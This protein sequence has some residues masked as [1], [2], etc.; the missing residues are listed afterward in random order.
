MAIAKHY[1]QAVFNWVRRWMPIDWTTSWL[2]ARRGG[3]VAFDAGQ[4]V[5]LRNVTDIDCLVLLG[6][7]GL[8]K[9]NEI[10][11]WASHL[12]DDGMAVD[13]LHGRAPDFAAALDGLLSSP[14]HA[15][16]SGDRKPW[17][18]LV[19]GL[20]EI[21]PSKEVATLLAG[22]LD[23]LFETHRETGRL[24]FIVT[25][26]TSG[27][28]EDFDRLFEDRW[29]SETLRKLALVPLDRPAIE[30]AIA[31]VEEDE[32]KRIDLAERLLAPQLR[33]L[34]GLPIFLKLLLARYR[35]GAVA[36]QQPGDLLP[37]AIEGVLANAPEEDFEKLMRVVG[38][39]A[40]ACLFSGHPRLSLPGARSLSD[41][42]PVSNIAGG[43]EPAASGPFVVTPAMMARCLHTGLFTELEPDVFEWSHRILSDF[44]AARYL[45][46]HQLSAEQIF[47]MVA[48]KEVAGPG[49][50]PLQL[51]EMAGWVASLSPTFFDLLLER[52]PEVLLRAQATTLDASQQ[53][54]LASALLQRIGNDDLLEQYH[55]LQP[56]LARLDH[57]GLAEQLRPVIANDEATPF[58]RR[59]AID[60][61]VASGSVELAD[62][63]ID[64]ALDT[65]RDA[66][67]RHLA[68]RAGV[69]LDCP[70]ARLRLK[71]LLASE[72]QGDDEDRL[73]GALLDL[74]WPDE[75]SFRELLGALSV[76]RK[77]NFIGPYQL[78]LHRFVPPDL[79]SEM[80]ADAL[81]WL[82]ERI[83]VDQ[84]DHGQL[85]GVMQGIFSAVAR[86]TADVNVRQ[87]LAEL[88]NDVGHEL[89]QIT[90]RQ[91]NV[92]LNWPQ[93]P[94]ARADL[95][96]A[97]MEKSLDPLRAITVISVVLPGLVVSEDLETL[98]TRLP[99]VGA[100]I[101]DA[102]TQ[103]I[104]DLAQNIPLDSLTSVWQMA[105]RIPQLAALLSQRYAVVIRSPAA[106]RMRQKWVSDEEKRKRIGRVEEAKT[107]WQENVTS[108]LD[109]IE[110][111]E[112]GLWW[113]LNL[114]L[115]YDP[116][117]GYD[118]QFE[119]TADLT[120]TPGW[121]ALG[122]N[123][124]DR[125]LR[126][127]ELYLNA[128]PLTDSS[129]L[130][131]NTSHRPANAGLRALA[132]LYRRRHEVLDRLPMETWEAWAP[133]I[134]GFLSNDFDDDGDAQREL[135]VESYRAAP[136]AIHDAITQIALGE[137]SKGLSKRVFDLLGSLFDASLA[138]LLERLREVDGLKGE[139]ARADIS[140][141]LVRHDEARAVDR[142]RK[143]LSATEQQTLPSSPGGQEAIGAAIEMCIRRPGAHWN[144]LLELRHSNSAMARAIWIGLAEEVSFDRTLHLEELS[145]YELAQ[146]YIDLAA[147]LPDQ[148]P[149]TSGARL[150]DVRDHVAQLSATVI[151]RLVHLGSNSALEQLYRIQR[152]LPALADKLRWSI[153]AA[154]QNLR[155]KAG[156]REDAAEILARIAD[157]SIALAGSEPH[158]SSGSPPDVDQAI[159]IPAGIDV[160]ARF[161][162][163]S[164]KL[165]L[166]SRRNILLV[167][168]E[169]SST[170][171][172]ISTLNRELCIALATIGHRIQCLVVDASDVDKNDAIGRSVRLVRTRQSAGITGREQLL[173]CERDDL[174]TTPDIVI[175]HDHVTGSYA[176]AIA[177]R[178]GAKYVHMLHTIPQE[179]EAL[180]DARDGIDRP[181]LG[182]EAKLAEQVALARA[183]DLIVAIGPRIEDHFLTEVYDPPEVVMMVPGLNSELLSM[184]LS[185]SGR[186]MNLCL[187]SGRME[188]ASLK[189]GRLA[190]D[191]VKHVAQSRTW[192]SGL[193]PKLS[194][195]GFSKQKADEEFDRI[196]FRKDYAQFVLC[197]SYSTDPL[198]LRKD[199]EK[200]A[201]IVMPS[202]AEGFGLTGLEA[203]AAGVPVVL[204][205]E[206][207]LAHYLLK[208][209]LNGGLDQAL[210]EPSIATVTRGESENIK[211]WAEKVDAILSDHVAAVERAAKLRDALR[212]RLSW[213]VVARKF[214]KDLGRLR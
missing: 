91:S 146:T 192:P 77:L 109:R 29:P 99:H 13:L 168:T 60:M 197:R 57:P 180:K 14:H 167:A 2:S 130:G 170:H 155:S 10:D 18:I 165:D 210:V 198:E 138:D 12:R 157:M 214:T 178:F 169:W 106:D 27:W 195:R 183:A 83:D 48:V 9:T 70:F 172:G 107:R 87:L 78:F 126:T 90:V 119:F 20:D 182:G 171:G 104:V 111:G 93:T 141:F 25:C 124:H 125:I 33:T 135:L 45:V 41:A 205:S 120:R 3:H 161:A 34:A 187:M 73:R 7:P 1:G 56:L 71:P 79:T 66:I 204:S 117:L 5:E 89:G 140:A 54:R 92:S 39:M 162:E 32:Q 72:L 134:I 98:L 40:A 136:S 15:A 80:A 74:Y 189:G 82:R 8:G 55:Q 131:T 151:G 211:A 28:S 112:A 123:D 110:G 62:T 156:K 37:Y 143:A 105:S 188:D 191:V 173:L 202:V 177:T 200:S 103:I 159:P 59:A 67:L 174:E 118:E 201:L 69:K 166:A 68:L 153:G 208:P 46:D 190:C 158:P 122:A 43:T 31:Q 21:A 203:I 23:R 26:R 148:P 160:R 129:W 30:Q 199:Y 209:E 175:G 115:F 206:S 133:A 84:R 64:V 213:D 53:S 176:R 36:P 52:Q 86:Q 61:A 102:W 149:E 184:Q 193:T 76:P 132:L 85:L 144:M 44:L 154:R 17:H 121:K 96:Q 58:K 181:I 50:I 113:E 147:L 114:Q 16:W 164:E 207:G 179:N 145:E 212:A 196:G 6:E 22:F 75:L 88:V 100:R 139:T 152:A 42:L 24:R 11:R 150:L 142:V 127:A 108:L 49:G 38:R 4:T 128:A 163:P 97:I 47:S 65:T 19:D 94:D 186:R 35:T 101:C 194:I 51:L 185:P 116:V 137:H 81:I 95:V 63:L